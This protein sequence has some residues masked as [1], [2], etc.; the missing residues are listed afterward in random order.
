M[1]YRLTR[2]A[3]DSPHFAALQARAEEALAKD[4]TPME[5]DAFAGCLAELADLDPEAYADMPGREIPAAITEIAGKP[6]N[7]RR[8]DRG[9]T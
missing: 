6:S 4:L 7:G 2:T 3:E 5:S 9:R 1:I 8:P